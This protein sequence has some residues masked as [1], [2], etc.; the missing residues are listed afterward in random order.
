M[1]APIGRICS[2]IPCTFRPT[3]GGFRLEVTPDEGVATREPK[4]TELDFSLGLGHA[5]VA[6]FH[7][8][9]PIQKNYFV[10]ARNDTDTEVAYA[11]VAECASPAWFLAVDA[12]DTLI[13]VL[14]AHATARLMLK[15]GI[16]SLPSP[17]AR[18]RSN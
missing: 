15:A 10:D 3:P 9:P 14:P 13:C 11:D 1:S 4:F 8:P 17:I 7:A 12:G 2:K 16:S 6:D 18:P 5:L